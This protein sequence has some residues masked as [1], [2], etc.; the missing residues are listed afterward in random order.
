MKP[1]RLTM[2]AFGSY[3]TVTEIDFSR[4]KKGL[5]LITGDTGAGKT[6]IFDAITYALY[7]QTS[8]GERNGN[9]MRSQYAKNSV[10]TYV[11]FEFLYAGKVYKVRRNPD[12]RI[13]RK[14]KNGTTKERKVAHGVELTLPDGTVYPEKKNATD[15]KIAEIIGLTVD[16]FTQIVMIAQ[17]DFLKLLYTKSDE[18]KQ[19]FSK[20]FRTDV[21]LRVQENLR[22][23]STLMDE[24]LQENERALVQEQGRIILPQ[25][26]EK[27]DDIKELSLDKLVDLIK[28]QEQKIAALQEQKRR[29]LEQL[30]R[31]ISRVEAENKLFITLE[32]LRTTEE[33]LQQQE[34]EEEERKR[35]I[36]A[37]KKAEKAAIEEDRFLDRLWQQK[38]TIQ[39]VE[40]MSR[41]LTEFGI[42]YQKQETLIKEWE[43]EL[44]AQ[45]ETAG[46]E[47]HHMEESL[48][49]YAKLSAARKRETEAKALL[50]KAERELLQ[51][52]KQ[53]AA[54]LSE[55]QKKLEAAVREQQESGEKWKQAVG[56]AETASKHYERTYR[57]FLAEQAGILAQALESDSP[58][59]VCGSTVHPVPAV[60]S[61]NAVSEEDVKQSRQ[62]RQRADEA[63][64]QSHHRF[65]EK[66]A[67]C[68]E[69]NLLLVQEQ[70]TQIDRKEADER[71]RDYVECQKE[72]ARIREG[73]LFQ[74][75][76]EVIAKI[77]EQQEMLRKKKADFDKKR[78]SQELL[79]Q[80][81]DVRQGQFLQEQEKAKQL[82]KECA[83][84]GKVFDE[85]LQ[86]A[87]FTREEYRKA[88]LS[89]KKVNAIEKESSDY[90]QKRQQNAGEIKALETATAGKQMSDTTEL[91]KQIF[92]GECERKRL[93][94]EHLVMHTAYTTNK[95]VLENSRS[96]MEQQ[97]RLREQDQIVKS[98][99]RTANGRLAGSAKI[100]FETYIQRQYFRQIINEANKRL[101][102]MSNQQ[103]MLKLKEEQSAGRKSNEGLDL[104]VYSLVTDSERD[105]KTLSGGESFLAALAMALGLSDIATRNAGAIHLDMMFIDEG[106]GSL[107]VQSRTQAIEVLDELAGNSRMIGIISHVTEMKEQIDRKLMVTRSDKGSRAVWE[108][109]L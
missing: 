5:F 67:I 4:Q 73:L 34:S 9:M 52:Q 17:G 71:N 33:K 1:L 47:I 62:K 44:K 60:L 79:K 107:D 74:T 61:E 10:E 109:E 100:D 66:K 30:N 11:E 29:E 83:Q 99:Y 54:R 78:N 36:A 72:V 48:P 40:K 70:S 38:E 14:L 28:E 22:R 12:Y 101:L 24:Q 19:I 50:E 91:T 46:K 35:L 16:Q 7:D 63:V 84:A 53:R 80:E 85:A 81:L 68:S 3:A 20:L 96:F 104:S 32:K 6:T 105:I 98:L 89:E 13:E 39:S 15:E 27:E 56:E 43:E 31:E 25:I 86:K 65:E 95:S 21:Y 45:T 41:W 49:E 75:E 106:F 26:E 51:R 103:F 77:K 64:E 59:P 108:N 93:E 58:C 8:G 76:E 55:L 23:R 94:R 18:R 97:T 42:K 57:S 102:T 2:S 92:E 82:E 87:G 37:A 90:L 88:R 69:I